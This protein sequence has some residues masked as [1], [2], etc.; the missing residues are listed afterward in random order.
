MPGDTLFGEANQALEGA[1]R[2]TSADKDRKAEANT[3]EVP[4]TNQG[5]EVLKDKMDQAENMVSITPQI[6]LGMV[7]NTGDK[8]WLKAVGQKM[9]ADVL[10]PL[11]THGIKLEQAKK[12]PKITQV[13]DKDG[14]VRHSVVYTDE[15][16]DEQQLLLDEG[17][18]PEALN[19]GRGGAGG[20][21]RGGGAGGAKKDDTLAKQKAF[22]A[23][24][25]KQ[26]ALLNDASKSSALKAT[27]PEQYQRMKEEYEKDQ[28]RYDQLKTQMGAAGAPAPAAG[29]KSAGSGDSSPFNPDDL[30]KEA[31]QN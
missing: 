16:G 2:T 8:E 3:A 30:I 29:G 18:T 25:E 21:K 13:Y 11:Y 27:D 5:L 19:K 15:N 14:K 6:A 7:H 20:G 26:A 23:S 22:M 12:A 24:H 9:R 10:M 1:S 17:M 28:D 31:L 4:G